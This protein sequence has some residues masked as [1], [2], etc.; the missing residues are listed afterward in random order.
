MT[1]QKIASAL[2]LV[3]KPWLPGYCWAERRSHTGSAFPQY[4]NCSKQARPG[5]LTCHWHRHL[6]DAAQQLKESIT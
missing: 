2:H 6:E 5:H 1:A 3:S 4:V